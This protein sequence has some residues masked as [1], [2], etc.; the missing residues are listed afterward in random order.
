M[1]IRNADMETRFLAKLDKTGDCWWWTGAT[2]PQG[3]G[4]YTIRWISGGRQTFLAHIFS[5]WIHK[6]GTGGLQ[7]CHAC[8]NPSCVNP[9]HLWLGTQKANIQDAIL[10]GRAKGYRPSDPPRGF[11]GPIRPNSGRPR[12]DRTWA[13]PIGPSRPVGRPRKLGYGI[14][15]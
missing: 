5:Y 11:I 8:D 10:K 2:S 15:A 3:Y 14:A 1:Y 12:I 9:G 6:G 7:V 4:L 13:K